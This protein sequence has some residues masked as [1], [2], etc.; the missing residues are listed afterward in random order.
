MAWF[1]GFLLKFSVGISGYRLLVMLV[2]RR[3][4]CVKY[5][6]MGCLRERLF[7]FVLWEGLVRNDRRG[8]VG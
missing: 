2:E 8:N 4:G 1:W 3:L 7:G 6:G 5:L